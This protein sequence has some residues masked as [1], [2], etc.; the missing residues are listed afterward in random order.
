MDTFTGTWSDLRGQIRRHWSR[1]T[2]HDLDVI[3]GRRDQLLVRLQQRYGIKKREAEREVAEFESTAT[4]SA[5][6]DQP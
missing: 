3:A 4:H 1:L 2:D 5:D 6:G